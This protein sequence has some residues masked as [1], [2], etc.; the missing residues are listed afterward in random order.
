M[1]ATHSIAITLA[2]VDPAVKDTPGT[3]KVATVIATAEA[4][5]R[6]NMLSLLRPT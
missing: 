2:C 6:I 5:I 3:K 4:K 1:I